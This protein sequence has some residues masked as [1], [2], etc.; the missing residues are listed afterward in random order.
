M[1]AVRRKAF[2][3]EQSAQSRAKAQIIAKYF[4][5]WAR[6]VGRNATKLAYV[7]LFAGRGRYENGDPSTPLLILEETIAEPRLRD[8]LVSMFNDA[9]PTA[10][11]A[12]ER[13]IAAL[14]GIEQLKYAPSV[15][16]G[17]VGADIAKLFQK[18]NLVPT[19][20]FIDPF[21]YKGLSRDLIAALIKDWASECVF[22]FNFNR[23]SIGLTNPK[24]DSHMRA[25][26]GAQWLQEV[27][28]RVAEAPPEHR[29][30]VI[31]SAL[32][33]GLRE[34]GAQ[35]VVTF[36][37]R[38]RRDGRTSHY[39]IFVTKHELGCNVM[40]DVMAG[41][42]SHHDADGV[43]SVRVR[44]P[45]GGAAGARDTRRRSPAAA[46]GQDPEVRRRTDD[47]CQGALRFA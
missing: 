37:F 23:I 15:H 27:R 35:H 8:I 20:A 44:C 36:R 30:R 32:K 7:D 24:V 2:F 19:L 12:L 4:S 25:I 22:F 17:E 1:A 6:I 31:V 43:P 46:E 28:T 39:L 11:K 16:T 3:A 40:R 5:V 18:T 13:E 33:G 21:G 10:T 42:S 26:F 14:P 38:R 47:E 34:L 9:D 29:E 45:D 41:M